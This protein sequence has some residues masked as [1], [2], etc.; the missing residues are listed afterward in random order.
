MRICPRCHKRVPDSAIY[1]PEDGTAVAVDHDPLIGWVILER[2]EVLDRIAV[3][4]T[5]T[6]YHARHV[7][8][9]HSLVV[10]VFHREICE[11]GSL[12][13]RLRQDATLVAQMGSPS[14]VRLSDIGLTQEGRIFVAMELVE[15]DPLDGVLA[16]EGRFSE[17]RA[18]AVVSQLADALGE[19]HAAGLAHGDLRPRNVVLQRRRDRDLVKLFGLET[20]RLIQVQL[21]N[22]DGRVA[23]DP[24][25]IS[26]EHSRGYAFDGRSD[27]YSLAL[28][29][30]EMVTGTPPFNSMDR[31]VEPEMLVD[32]LTAASPH[33]AAAIARALHPEPVH[34]YPSVQD[35]A[36]ALRGRAIA[37]TPT[38]QYGDDSTRPVRPALRAVTP[39]P[40]EPQQ[41]RV[42][43]I[44]TGNDQGG[45]RARVVDQAHRT[46]SDGGGLDAQPTTLNMRE[47][48]DLLKTQ[49]PP[50][51]SPPAVEAPHRARR[52]T[53]P[54]Q[55]IV[56]GNNVPEA[57]VPSLYSANTLIPGTPASEEVFEAAAALREMDDGWNDPTPTG[58]RADS[59]TPVVSVTPLPDSASAAG[60]VETRR[61][62]EEVKV[63]EP[64]TMVDPSAGIDAEEAR[65]SHGEAAPQAALS[66]L[67][68]LQTVPLELSDLAPVSTGEE[69]LLA[70][71]A[72]LG[73]AV[74][75]ALAEPA[76]D[77]RH[78]ELGRFEEDYRDAPPA[79]SFEPAM[80]APL[81]PT[82]T[83]R[84]RPALLD[85]EYEPPKRR[86]PSW[87]FGAAAAVAAGAV[88]LA[89]VLGRGGGDRPAVEAPLRLSI[90]TNPPGATVFVDGRDTGKTTP[91]A[92]DVPGGRDGAGQPVV[93]LKLAGHLDTV[94]RV[95]EAQIHGAGQD[96]TVKISSGLTPLP[97]SKPPATGTAA[98]T[99]EGAPPARASSPEAVPSAP[100]AGEREAG[101]AAR[102]RPT[103]RATLKT[104]ATGRPAR[105]SAAA[106]QPV[107]GQPASADEP[108]AP[109]S[110]A[111]KPAPAGEGKG[112]GSGEH[113]PDG[114]VVGSGSK[115]DEPGKDKPA[116]KA[117]EP[118]A[119]KAPEPP[120]AKTPDPPAAKEPTPAK[121][122]AKTG[123][124]RP[125]WA[126]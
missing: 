22:R 70:E 93:T 118:P 45:M 98:G 27:T 41:G 126:D 106:A 35:F 33:F 79:P 31:D 100:V 110:G 64:A 38:G 57:L 63:G 67:P 91:T 42:Q 56:R 88:A 55:T 26:P 114:P 24:R 111:D 18:A 122:P 71:N 77:D 101:A 120:A 115:A 102:A 76:A 8:L 14:V 40:P 107:A 48:L 73:E 75:T 81:Q 94:V 7:G 83:E 85:L 90:A 97:A 36:K 20:G 113:V 49:V 66:A 39:L 72:T 53:A 80:D 82:A 87:V 15:G 119:A 65:G 112:P 69:A 62:S 43:V 105:G 17:A 44:V 51:G 16:L 78:A 2:Y 3:G 68:A 11:D 34:R 104:P 28:L 23:P 10:K 116:A 25:Y 13:R 54:A 59:P 46:T 123:I 9:D 124:K 19:A 12:S 6:I 95:T 5:G 1:C 84:V 4:R 52:S 32:R 99:A 60:E 125:T 109:G 92:V 30:M 86:V 61:P 108:K 47:G 117:P 58:F 37:R 103:G 29:A 50:S 89:I 21:G 96:G 74:A 121:Q